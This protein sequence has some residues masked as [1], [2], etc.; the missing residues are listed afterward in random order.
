MKYTR[1]IVNGMINISKEPIELENFRVGAAGEI[2]G[3]SVSHSCPICRKQE[4]FVCPDAG[5][6]L[7]ACYNPECMQRDLKKSK[8]GIDKLL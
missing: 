5:G 1:I 3:D 7:L 2:I 6:A 4:F 8:R